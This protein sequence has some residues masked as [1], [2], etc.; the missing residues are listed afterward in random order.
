MAGIK[1]MYMRKNIILLTLVLILNIL[2]ANAD[3]WDD[4]SNVDRMWDGQKSI[5]NQQFEQVMD[6]LEEKGKQQEEKIKQKKRKKMFGNG[7]TLHEELNPD[8]EVPE[9]QM[10]K[11]ASEDGVL[12]N[13]PVMLVID[14]KPLEKGFYKVFAEKDKET[15][16]LY[17][18]FYQSQFFKCK[19][20]VIPT[21]DDF[22]E[23]ML[24]FAKILPFNESFVKF[25]FGSI[26][27]NAY[28]YLP[29]LND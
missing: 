6:K 2:S 23:D 10:P 8:K 12:I 11:S 7:T 9:I 17:V 3:S 22:G 4:F 28:A 20:E 16:K 25:I 26:D 19:I 13:L 21:D 18:N 27:F 5:T 29:Y 14:G 1:L 15:S 24:N